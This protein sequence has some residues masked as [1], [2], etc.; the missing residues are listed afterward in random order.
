VYDY[1]YDTARNVLDISWQ[2]MFDPAGVRDYAELLKREFVRHGF[3]PGYRLR[4][5]MSDSAVQ[6]QTVLATFREVFA[7]FPKASRIAVVTQSAIARLQIQRE[8][9]Q[10]YLRIFDSRDTALDWLLEAVP[11]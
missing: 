1:H 11:A 3:R 4:M 9:T 10:P 5:D 6:P 2:G 8:M 7:D